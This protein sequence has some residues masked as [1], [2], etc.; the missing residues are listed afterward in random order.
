MMTVLASTTRR[1]NNNSCTASCGRSHTLLH[2]LIDSGA[3]ILFITNSTFR[4]FVF[5]PLTLS[6]SARID[7]D[8][9]L[10]N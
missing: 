2:T 5:V 1:A 3:P 10:I 6:P 7:P 4:G 9:A 8:L